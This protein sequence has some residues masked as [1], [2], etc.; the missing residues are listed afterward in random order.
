MIN[1]KDQLLNQLAIAFGEKE[2]GGFEIVDR[3]AYDVPLIH[4]STDSKIKNFIPRMSFRIY[5]GETTAL[6]RISTCPDLK[7]CLMGYGDIAISDHQNTMKNGKNGSDIVYTIYGFEKW[8]HA[9]IPP[10][11][12]LPDVQHSN[13]HWLIA[14][15]PETRIYKPEI[16]GEFFLRSIEYDIRSTET[17]RNY[18]LLMRVTSPFNLLPGMKM[19]K[20]FY[21]ILIYNFV[22][23]IK[24]K[25]REESRF[26]LDKDVQ[27]RPI[28]EGEYVLNYNLC[29]SKKGK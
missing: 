29:R 12:Y 14:Y 10:K 28:R 4:I 1:S 17:H 16:C 22:P 20:G 18:R 8:E 6:P 5:P 11:K 3:G 2:L 25:D 23:P 13:E 27:V 7:G 24:S 26:I 9:V 19:S 21:E 15:S